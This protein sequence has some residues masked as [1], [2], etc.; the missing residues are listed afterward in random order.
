[1]IVYLL[2][3]DWNH[4]R[5]QAV[6]FLT[7]KNINHFKITQNLGL[8]NIA[9]TRNFCGA[10]C[11]PLQNSNVKINSNGF[12]KRK[13]YRVIHIK[14]KGLKIIVYYFHVSAQ[15]IFKDHPSL[16]TCKALEAGGSDQ[17]NDN[18]I[19]SDN[20][21]KLTA[22]TKVL[23]KNMIISLS[24]WRDWPHNPLSSSATVYNYNN[25]VDLE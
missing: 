2:K 18:D 20:L 11:D 12:R 5:C 10:L 14:A 24:M 16:L 9:W 6:H 1:M 15:A 8:N 13:T 25:L 17:L 22:I 23:H 21:E 19:F 3:P 4:N 7:K